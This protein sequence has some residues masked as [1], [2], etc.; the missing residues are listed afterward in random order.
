MSA[1]FAQDLKREAELMDRHPTPDCMIILKLKSS[2][3]ERSTVKEFEIVVNNVLLDCSPYIH[4]CKVG[5]GCILVSMCAPKPLMG[6]LVKM[7]KTR[8][9]YLC[10][11]GVILL[12]IGDKIILDKREKEVYSK[13]LITTYVHIYINSGI[14]ICS[15]YNYT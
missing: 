11:I 13:L 8:L 2:R 9:P 4:I 7:A 3:A 5:E 6:A 14:H 1:A 15:T 10:D 12:Q